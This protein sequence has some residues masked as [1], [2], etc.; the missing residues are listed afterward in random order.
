MNA[1]LRF[2]VLLIIRVYECD[3]VCAG[4]SFTEN[5]TI[6]TQ[7]EYALIILGTFLVGFFAESGANF[8]L[9]TDSE[10]YF[11]A[12]GFGGLLAHPE[13]EARTL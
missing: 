8:I 10:M 3:S 7:L 9:R 6:G 11:A 5:V 13:M 4:R 12:F 1:V 2:R